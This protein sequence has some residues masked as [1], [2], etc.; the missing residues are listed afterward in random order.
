MSHIPIII[1]WA[2]SHGLCGERPPKTFY[3]WPNSSGCSGEIV[4][5][6]AAFPGLRSLCL[7]IN[8]SLWITG[9]AG[10]QCSCV[11]VW[12]GQWND[13]SSGGLRA[14]KNAVWWDCRLGG[15]G[16]EG[17]G[18]GQVLTA[19]RETKDT[20]HFAQRSPKKNCAINMVQ[21]QRGER[22]VMK[23]CT[24][25]SVWVKPVWIPWCSTDI[26]HFLPERQADPWAHS[27]RRT[28]TT[29]N[30][31]LIGPDGS[32]SERE[33]QVT[34]KPLHLSAPTWYFTWLSSVPASHYLSNTISNWGSLCAV[35]SSSQGVPLCVGSSET[36]SHGCG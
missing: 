20:L 27:A 18:G 34:G 28:I 12:A 23:S 26:Y 14:R 29:L 7:A 35:R 1:L 2:A 15:R 5:M 13:W 30:G 22:F 31:L 16:G 33:D 8:K 11:H 9:E 10:S 19:W 32:Q 36:S 6:A 4:L 3:V 25:E 17:R 24:R 21:D